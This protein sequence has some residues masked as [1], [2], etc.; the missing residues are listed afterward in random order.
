MDS[1]KLLQL[2]ESHKEMAQ[3]PGMNFSKGLGQWHSIFWP[4]WPVHRPEMGLRALHHL[5]PTPN[6]RIGLWGPTFPPTSPMCWDRA[7][8]HV[9]P[10]VPDLVCSAMGSSA[11]RK[12]RYQGLSALCLGSAVESTHVQIERIMK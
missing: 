3:L 12:T 6:D 10:C 11:G 5:Q 4:Q 1:I 9:P 2:Q 7:L 8:G